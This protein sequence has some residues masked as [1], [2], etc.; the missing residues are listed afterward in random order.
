MIAASAGITSRRIG[1]VKSML[2]TGIV[3]ICEIKIAKLC[4]PLI[5]RPGHLFKTFAMFCAVTEIHYL[6]W[7][8]FSGWPGAAAAAACARVLELE[9]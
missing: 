8:G 6:F 1:M 5:C 3:C 9:L 4:V 2:T 7:P